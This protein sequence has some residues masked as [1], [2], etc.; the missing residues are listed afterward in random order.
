MPEGSR[1]ALVLGGTG[2][3]GGHCLRLLLDSGL[4]TQVIALSRRKVLI[5]HSRLHQV[6]VPDFEKL[7][8]SLADIQADDVFC[9]LG[10]T[11]KRAGSEENFRRVD[12]DYPLELARLMKEKGAQHFLVVTAMGADPHSVFFYS[13]IKGELERRL[14]ELNFRYLSIFRPS[15][16]LGDREEFRFLEYLGGRVLGLLSPFMRGRLESLKPIEAS[17]VARAMLEEAKTV[18]EGSRRSAY[19]EIDSDMMQRLAE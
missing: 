11:I 8:A 4:Y 15:L 19:R 13:R 9:C 1:T 17:T 10:T 6:V 2:L 16:L 7:A 18:A 5:A 14:T 12:L 3:I